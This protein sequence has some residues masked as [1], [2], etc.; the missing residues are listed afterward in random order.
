[1]PSLTARAIEF[2]FVGRRLD[3]TIK[4]GVVL[5]DVRST[6]VELFNVAGKHIV[7]GTAAK[8]NIYF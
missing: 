3:E 7:V 4:T 8:N 5:T 1:M 6:S 2:R